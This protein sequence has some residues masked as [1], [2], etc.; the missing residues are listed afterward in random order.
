MVKLWGEWKER[1]KWCTSDK[2]QGRHTYILQLPKEQA[3][4]DDKDDDATTDKDRSYL[5]NPNLNKLMTL[6]G[7]D[8]K[9]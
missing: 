3:S 8:A 1:L 9:A 4:D 6:V 2:P 7:T 5:T